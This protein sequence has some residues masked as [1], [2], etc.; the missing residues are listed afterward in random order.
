MYFVLCRSVVTVFYQVSAQLDLPCITM[1][2]L[3]APCAV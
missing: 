1:N 2:V 3:H